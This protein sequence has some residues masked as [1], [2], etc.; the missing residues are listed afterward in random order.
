MSDATQ[1]LKSPLMYGSQNGH[2]Q[3]VTELLQHG[4]RVD[5]QNKV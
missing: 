1:L 5:M 3:V 2:V 4:A